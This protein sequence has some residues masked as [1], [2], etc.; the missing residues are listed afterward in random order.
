[1]RKTT[2]INTLAPTRLQSFLYRNK[3]GRVCLKLLITR[4]V[5]SVAGAVLNSKFSS[6]FVKGFVKNN[7]IDLSEFEKEKFS[8][9]NDFFTRKIR[10]EL[11]PISNDSSELISPADSRLLCLD[12]D[13]HLRFNI[14]NS[15]YS[16]SS[17]LCDEALADEFLGGKLLI[18][19]LCV[20]DYHRY[21]FFDDGEILSTKFISGKLHTVQPIALERDDF[22][23]QNCRE[24]TVMQ[25]KN[26]GKAVMVEIGAL[27]VGKIV[28]HLSLGA[29]S[30][31]QEKGYF[32]FG[33]STVCLLL[34]KGEVS[35]DK[36]IIENTK[37]GLETRVLFGETIGRK[38]I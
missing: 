10:P 33:G 5:S 38:D 35:V 22:F 21:C 2:D 30:K 11:R 9:Y 31:G 29:F 16:L 15:Y 1:M 26:F 19:R 27:M 14:K 32:E 7:G 23:K 20:D 17:F 3:L 37:N 12:I 25:T 36:E 18:F 8:S 28:N 13:E 34:K 6:A 4:T 24:V